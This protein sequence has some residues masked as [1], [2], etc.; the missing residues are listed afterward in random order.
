M[1]LFIKLYSCP[2]WFLLPSTDNIKKTRFS[3][4]EEIFRTTEILH[5]RP[6]IKM[7]EA[8]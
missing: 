5:I 8:T 1:T 2:Q 7:Y 6:V 3:N 4:I